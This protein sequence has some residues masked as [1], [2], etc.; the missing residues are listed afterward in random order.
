MYF[1]LF[2]YNYT[3]LIHVSFAEKVFIRTAHV[4]LSPQVIHGLQR[5][6]E[7]QEEEIM[8]LRMQISQLQSSK[9]TVTFSDLDNS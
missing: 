2:I 7:E 3:V 5:R 9:V 8:Q 4:F 6:V 1:Y